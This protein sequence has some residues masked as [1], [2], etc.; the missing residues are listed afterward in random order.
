MN[1][2]ERIQTRNSVGL[3]IIYI[4]EKMLAD[5]ERGETLPALVLPPVEQSEEVKVL[6]NAGF[7][8]HK[9]VVE[10]FKRVQEQNERYNAHNQ[11][12]RALRRNTEAL[13]LLVRAREIY[14]KDTLLLPY[15]KFI[16]LL[17]KYGLECGS[18]QN[19]KGDVPS[20]KLQEIIGLQNKSSF[21]GIIPLLPVTKVE[22]NYNLLGD[23]EYEAVKK[24]LKKFPFVRSTN[25]FFD[26][27]VKFIDG[28]VKELHWAE[29]HTGTITDFFIAAPKKMFKKHYEV[30]TRK[31]PF[32]CAYTEYGI[33]IF[34]RWGEEAK[35]KIIRKF[36][37]FNDK[38]DEFEKKYLK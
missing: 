1:I 4:M 18:F 2:V 21:R 11:L 9:K 12:E 20:D 28:S 15:D 23:D 22:W 34:T 16:S 24:K 35:D 10:Y 17:K 19:Y 38:L 37:A 29:V 5:A 8:N 30:V 25:G 31:D 13:K 33:L 14:G 26:Q 36:E 7:V 27:T 32:I 6:R 3:G